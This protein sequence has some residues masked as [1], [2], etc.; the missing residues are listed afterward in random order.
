LIVGWVVGRQ[1]WARRAISL[2]VAG[3]FL[4][5]VS[6]TGWAVLHHLQPAYPFGIQKNYV[7]DMLAF[8]ALLV[9]ARPDWL[10]WQGRTWRPVVLSVCLLGI[11]ASQSKQAIV[12]LVIGAGVLLIRDRNVSRRSKAILLAI[13]PLAVF[14]YIAA[15]HELAS[16]NVFNG[17][18]QR[19]TWLHQSLQ[20][21]HLAPWFG[22]GLRWWYTGRFV[23]A[24]QPPNAEL[25]VLTS[26]GIV[27]LVG[28]IVLIVGSFQVLRRL[29]HR[30][31]T[32]ALAILIMRVVQGQL[33][34]FWVGA[35]GSLPWMVIGVALG[36]L[37]LERCSVDHALR[38]RDQ[39]PRAAP[40]LA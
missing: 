2:F 35:Q 34:I 1:G 24:F 12:S 8:A 29:P 31:G 25:E 9:Y 26:A 5:A 14:A 22:V 23:F 17:A 4:L 30:F 20:L 11:L 21:W 39:A 3:A 36:V 7:G 15:S 13:V 38:T 27:G 40:K 37:A 32:L 10:G 19:L 18:H 6:A 28:F 16:S 33:D